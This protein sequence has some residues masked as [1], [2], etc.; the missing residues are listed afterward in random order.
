MEHEEEQ[1]EEE[2]EECQDLFKWDV[3]EGDR[4]GGREGG[5]VARKDQRKEC[6]CVRVRASLYEVVRL[7]RVVAA[8]NK[9]ENKRRNSIDCKS[10][11]SL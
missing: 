11:I 8:N 2:E 5:I 6:I 10:C 3:G 7:A 1:E 4:E 9:D